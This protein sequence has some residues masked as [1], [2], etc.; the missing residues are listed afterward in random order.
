MPKELGIA[1]TWVLNFQ[2]P[3]KKAGVKEVRKLSIMFR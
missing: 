2:W 1:K 3:L